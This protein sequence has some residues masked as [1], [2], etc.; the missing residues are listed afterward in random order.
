LKYKKLITSCLI[1][2]LF[3][4]NCRGREKLTSRNFEIEPLTKP[5]ILQSQKALDFTS[6]F[7][8]LQMMRA[9]I[10]KIEKMPYILLN[11][12]KE[13]TLTTIIIRI[14]IISLFCTCIYILLLGMKEYNAL[15]NEN[16]R[17]REDIFL[18]VRELRRMQYIWGNVVIGA[19]YGHHNAGNDMI[20]Q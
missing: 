15:A 20:A 16:A 3:L 10:T 19:Q 5:T 8:M 9:K 7:I 14:T 13:E 6:S 11:D 4:T 17:L 1:A 18:Q 2:I 12:K